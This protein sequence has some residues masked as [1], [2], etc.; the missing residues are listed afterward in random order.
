MQMNVHN[1]LPCN[2]YIILDMITDNEPLLTKYISIPRESSSLNAGAFMAGI[3]ESTL[4]ASQFPCQVTAHSTS[5]DLFPTRTTFLIKFDKS[6][7]IRE[8][9]LDSK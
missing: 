9:N 6:V 1:S 5:S 3:I 4:D 2:F 8:Q 7:M